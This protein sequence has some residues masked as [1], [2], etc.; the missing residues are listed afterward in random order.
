VE[1]I[2]ILDE[3][4]AER[5]T[6]E[7]RKALA[8]LSGAWT[9]VQDPGELRNDPAVI[10]NGYVPTVTA[11]NGAPYALPTNPV[12]FDQQHVVPTGAPEH[13]QHTEEVLLEA[14]ISWETIE[15]YKDDGAVL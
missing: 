5:T 1:L 9:V 6:D 2:R 3:I 12:Q 8:P 14:G 7:W 10:A 13:G 11:M 15:R 4:F